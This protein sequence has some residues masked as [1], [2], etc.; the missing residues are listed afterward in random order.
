MVVF[1]RFDP[2][3]FDPLM[4]ATMSA[5]LEL[6]MLKVRPSRADEVKI[7]RLLESAIIDQVNAGKR[8]RQRLVEMAL[9]T[10]AVAQ[11]ISRPTIKEAPAPAASGLAPGVSTPERRVNEAAS[12]R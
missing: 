1:A 10:L 2:N 5:A 3:E 7:K 11:N 9:A 12:R 6:A 4:I 8:N